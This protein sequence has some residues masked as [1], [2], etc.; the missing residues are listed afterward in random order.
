L[1]AA[2]EPGS[3]AVAMLSPAISGDQYPVGDEVIRAIEA[4][5]G[6][7][8]A[9]QDGRVD[10]RTVLTFQLRLAGFSG[11]RIAMDQRCSAVHPD[12]FS[13]RGDAGKTGRGGLLLG[14]NF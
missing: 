14:W 11:D 6:G 8:G 9:C 7:P 5:P 1:I 10:L 4:L 13:Y 12:L 2:I 3:E